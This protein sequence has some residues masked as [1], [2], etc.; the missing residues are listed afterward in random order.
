MNE[1]EHSP[2]EANLTPRGRWWFKQRGY[3]GVGQPIHPFHLGS[4]R[5]YARRRFRKEAMQS[6]ESRRALKFAIRG[7]SVLAFFHRQLAP[8][9]ANLVGASVEPSYCY[10]TCYKPGAELSG[11]TGDEDAKYSLDLLLDCTPESKESSAWPLRL[12]GKVSSIGIRQNIGDA[13]LYRSMDV[14]RYR[15]ALP[16]GMTSTSVVFHYAERGEVAVERDPT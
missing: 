8:I 12:D 4:L 7:D 15:T 5:R 16:R 14:K 9:V 13:L 2:H 3:V 6:D 1:A 10:A 11:T